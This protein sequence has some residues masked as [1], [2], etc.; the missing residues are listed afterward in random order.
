[1]NILSNAIQ[2]IN[3]TKREDG[4]ITITTQLKNDF[5]LISISDNG[6][7][8]PEEVKKKLFEPFFT[9]KPVGEG[10]GLG[11]SIVFTI[12]EKVNGK[13]QVNSEVGT[14]TEFLI[15]LPITHTNYQ[16]T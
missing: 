14:G 12:I 6:M 10:T 13:I 3:E 11:L 8:I 4:K 7:G 15:T 2:A 9:T 16:T 5:V 1:M